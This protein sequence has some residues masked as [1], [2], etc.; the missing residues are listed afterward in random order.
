MAVPEFLLDRRV[1]D[2]YLQK[3][4]VE[5]KSVA[6]AMR[7]LPDVENNAM[8]AGEPAEGEA[9]VEGEAEPTDG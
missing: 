8:P 5:K 2:R 3:G 9:P 7:S 6:E 4:L 1:R